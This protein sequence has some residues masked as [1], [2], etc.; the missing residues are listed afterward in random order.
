MILAF[1]RS[2]GY[3][4]ILHAMGVFYAELFFV[5]LEQ[6]LGFRSAGKER[7]ELNFYYSSVSFCK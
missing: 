4:P 7:P 1:E 5:V 3:P 2:R 6:E